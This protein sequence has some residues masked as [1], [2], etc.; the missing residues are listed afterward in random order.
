M[1]SSKSQ[2]AKL[3]S[4]KLKDKN[5]CDILEKMKSYKKFDYFQRKDEDF[6]MKEYFK[7]LSLEKSRIKFSLESKMTRTVRT[8]FFGD[9]TFADKLWVC[10]NCEKATDSIPHIKICPSFAHLRDSRL[11]L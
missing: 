6:E 8:H 7:V 11:K 10:Q 2:W 5:R 3:L 1:S 4:I 9:K